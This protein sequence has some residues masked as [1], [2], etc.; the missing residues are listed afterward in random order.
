MCFPAGHAGAVSKFGSG[1]GYAFCI[2]TG[3]DG[4]VV[5]GHRSDDS[6]SI[7][8]TPPRQKPENIMLKLRST[9]ESSDHP[10]NAQSIQPAVKPIVYK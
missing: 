10:K 5:V 6:M 2:A 1:R 8:T 7:V 9:D 4:Q 3:A